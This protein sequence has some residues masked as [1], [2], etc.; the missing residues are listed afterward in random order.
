ML[1]TVRSECANFG[2]KWLKLPSE[3]LISNSAKHTLVGRT[4]GVAY[5]LTVYQ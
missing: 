5:A 4:N 2:H 3:I 1:N